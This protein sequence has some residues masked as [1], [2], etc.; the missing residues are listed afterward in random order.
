MTEPPFC[1]LCQK[2]YHRKVGFRHR[3]CVDKES[4]RLDREWR[5]REAYSRETYP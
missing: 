4:R 1:D 3:R 2:P 5:Q